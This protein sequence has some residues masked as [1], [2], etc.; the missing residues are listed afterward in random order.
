MNRNEM[1]V[2][3]YLAQLRLNV[4]IEPV[5]RMCLMTDSVDRSYLGPNDHT[6]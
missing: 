1:L 6:Y 3:F 4:E 5:H 2:L